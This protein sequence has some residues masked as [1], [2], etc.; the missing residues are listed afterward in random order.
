MPTA[1]GTASPPEAMVSRNQFLTLF[2]KQLQYQDPTSPMETDG[3][4][5]Q[6]AQLAQVEGIQSMN[7]GISALGTKLD[8][9]VAATINTPDV[10]R[11]QAIN[12]G[13]GLLGLSVRYGGGQ[14]DVGFVEEIK[15]DNGQILVRIGT[16]F[17][18][19][20]NVTGVSYDTSELS[21]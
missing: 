3:F 8:T 21:R 6:L 7:S 13:T 9:L 15:P 14:S 2:A 18:P 4:L 10:E 16:N 12:A 5:Q 20:S 11:M 17:Y 19:I 1:I